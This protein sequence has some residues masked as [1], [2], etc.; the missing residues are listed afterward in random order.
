MTLRRVLV[1]AVVVVTSLVTLGT[2]AAAAATPVY[3]NYVALGDSYT[4]GPFIPLMRLDPIGCARSTNNYPALLAATLHVRRFTDV[5]CGGADTTN[6]TKS[7]SV[8]LFGT[9]PPQ[10]NALRPNT[11][12]VTVGIGGNDDSVFGTVVGTCPGLRASDPHGAPCQAHFTVNGQDTL[13]ADIADTQVKVTAVVQGIHQRSPH[14]KVLVIGYPRIAPATGTCPDVLPFADGDYK[15][16]DSIERALNTAV[17]N[18]AAAADAT[19]VDTY[20]PSFGHDACAGSH[21]WIQGQS[22]NL[23]AAAPYHPRKAAMVGETAIIAHVLGVNR[24]VTNA[25]PDGPTAGVSTLTA[26][27]RALLN[28]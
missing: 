5:S 2:S 13:L 27:A 18:A 8:P 4:S 12:L 24:S 19:Y 21:A 15:Y 7:Q 25:A 14:A 17:A 20:G 9:N 26:L 11:D 22:L 16:L 10:F 1:A 28:G 23:F 3:A 6:M